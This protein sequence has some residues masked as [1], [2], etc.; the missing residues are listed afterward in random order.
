[1][2]VDEYTNIQNKFDQIKEIVKEELISINTDVLI[3]CWNAAIDTA[4]LAIENNTVKD[5]R[6]LKVK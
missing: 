6:K 1:M 3:H 4:A 5:I 2:T